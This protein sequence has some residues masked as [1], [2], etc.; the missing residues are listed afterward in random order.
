MLREKPFA[1]NTDS[2]NATLVI[3]RSTSY[4]FNLVVSNYLN[5]QLIGQTVGKSYFVT[6]AKPGTYYLIAKSD[7]YCCRKM[8]VDAGK[9]YYILQAIY[10][11]EHRF[12]MK[13]PDDFM[14]DEKE[15]ACYSL[16]SDPHI[17]Y[18]VIT[19]TEFK[20]TCDQYE[21][22]VTLSEKSGS[23]K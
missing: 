19:E 2:E 21:K 17:P 15:L 1:I 12:V 9:V 4:K 14:N 22:L 23:Y 10:P 6:K 20:K 13:Q 11:K 8:T 3:Y 7:T 18:P 16:E 5:N